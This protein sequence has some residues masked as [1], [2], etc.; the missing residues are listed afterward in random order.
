MAVLV[1]AGALAGVVAAVLDTTLEVRARAV[2]R[3]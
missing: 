3:P 2:A 1:W